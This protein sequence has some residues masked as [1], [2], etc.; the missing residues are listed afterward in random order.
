MANKSSAW[1][2]SLVERQSMSKLTKKPFYIKDVNAPKDY[3]F[4]A[5][6][7]SAEE[8]KK[9]PEH[10]QS[11]EYVLW[12]PDRRNFI[13][14][15]GNVYKMYVDDEM[16]RDILRPYEAEEKAS[17]REWRC[18]E[19]DSRGLIKRC[20]KDCTKCKLFI[21]GYDLSKT[22]GAPLSVDTISGDDES[23]DLFE[24]E[25]GAQLPINDRSNESQLD[26]LIEQK[27]REALIKEIR[28][29]DDK[30]KVVLE[31]TVINNMNPTEIERHTGIARST[32]KDRLNKGIAILKEKLKNYRN[33]Q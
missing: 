14:L 6:Y 32:V 15:E 24:F 31:L 3:D 20:D 19:F 22:M 4:E 21:E 29:L 8:L 2:Y 26:K 33:L 11:R 16:L 5:T 10:I 9:M 27:K 13:V 30:L 23:D 28:L 18:K 7:I 25:D 12:R 17:Q 1:V